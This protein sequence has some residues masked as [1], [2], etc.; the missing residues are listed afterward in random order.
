MTKNYP[1]SGSSGQSKILPINLL[2]LA[3]VKQII[4]L[5]RREYEI[6][7]LSNGQSAEMKLCCTHS[8][9]KRVEFRFVRYGSSVGADRTMFNSLV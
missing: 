5:S 3:R 7:Q 8:R 1:M 2:G 6:Y 4:R 9:A